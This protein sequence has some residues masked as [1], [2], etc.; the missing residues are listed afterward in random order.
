MNAPSGPAG[1]HSFFCLDGHTAGNP[2]R[3]VVAGAPPLQ[4]PTMSARRADFSA[5]WDWIR[6]ALM[7]EPRGHELMSGA[8]L[9]P[10]L[11][12]THDAALLFI[13]VDGCLPMCGHVTIGAASFVIEQGLVVPRTP[14]RLDFATPAGRITATYAL[15]GGKV[16]QV[17][18]LNI[19][20]F[21]AAEG[22]ALDVPGIGELVVDIAYGG[23]FYAI[24]EPQRNYA[25]LESLSPDDILRLSPLV[26]RAANRARRVVHP[27]DPT[28]A[29][30]SH[31]MWTGAPRHPRAHGRNAVFYGE[32]AIDR[33]PCGTGT[34]ARLAQLAAK[35]RLALGDEF[36]HESLIGTLFEARIEETLS[37]GP[38]PAIRPSIAGTAHLFAF[39]TIFVDPSDP[40]ALGFS[41]WETGGKDD[42]GA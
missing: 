39:N 11:D 16:S 5:R 35:G 33:S 2:V 37:L 3:L 20:S 27:E 30:V 10:P 6:R 4:G 17:R 25:G 24:V 36:I 23:N 42:G 14:G 31:V 40:M 13:E 34:S 22:V 9:Y 26:R 18:F 19:P 28:I 15:E 7:W 38:H 32:R 21:L 8:I 12:D 29:G 1:R 41:L